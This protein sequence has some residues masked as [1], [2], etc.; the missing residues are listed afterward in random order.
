MI[1]FKINKM[2]YIKETD[3]KEWSDIG[4][5]AFIYT[6]QDPKWH[7]N[8]SVQHRISFKTIILHPYYID[9]EY[10]SETCLTEPCINPTLNEIPM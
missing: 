7:S 10:Y 9:K 4:H 5:I 8:C 2:L 1:S 3:I 6:M